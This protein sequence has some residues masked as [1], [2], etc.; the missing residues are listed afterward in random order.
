ML[1]ELY[2]LERF[3]IHEEMEEKDREFPCAPPRAPRH[4]LPAQP[5]PEGASE[6]AS[7]LS[8]ARTCLLV[9]GA[10]HSL[11]AAVLGTLPVELGADRRWGA[12]GAHCS[13]TGQ[14]VF[15][16]KLPGQCRGVCPCDL[17]NRRLC[18]NVRRERP[19]LGAEPRVHAQAGQEGGAVG[20]GRS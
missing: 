4:S 14:K 11:T 10:L 16:G 9:P 2:L 19:R 20:R 3:Q 6:G 5:R 7:R 13:V 8:S 17:C 1:S 18:G 15:P 12:P